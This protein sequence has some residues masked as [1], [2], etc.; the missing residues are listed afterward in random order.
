MPRDALLVIEALLNTTAPPAPTM[1][2]PLCVT[3]AALTNKFAAGDALSVPVLVNRWALSVRLPPDALT[4][5]ALLI[6][7][8]IWPLPLKVAPAATVIVPVP[9]TGAPASVIDDVRDIALLIVVVALT[10]MF[11]LGRLNGGLVYRNPLL[12]IA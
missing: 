1:M 9:P 12:L 2:L 3:V 4:V 8:A 5:P 7:G 6:V 11:R 10:P